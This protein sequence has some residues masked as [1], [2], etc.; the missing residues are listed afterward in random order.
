MFC[1]L[2]VKKKKKKK[3]HCLISN[4]E[5]LVAKIWSV[6]FSFLLSIFFSLHITGIFR[7]KNDIAQIFWEMNAFSA[8]KT[9]R[10]MMQST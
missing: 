8:D 3:N 9:S 4:V 6:K 1:G 7:T 5:N 10:F 2:N